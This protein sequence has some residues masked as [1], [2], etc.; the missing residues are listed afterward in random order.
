MKDG[1]SAA[2]SNA[3]ASSRSLVCFST[4]PL[5]EPFQLLVN[6]VLVEF[7]LFALLS[8]GEGV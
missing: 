6:S 4:K 5:S 7:Y 2:L 8:R 1:S 3:R